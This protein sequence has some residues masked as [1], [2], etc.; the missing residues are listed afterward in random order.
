M[1][2]NYLKIAFRQLLRNKTF[3]AINI[4]GLAVGMS[5]FMLLALWVHNE[6]S[7]DRFHSKKERVYEL[8]NKAEWS[9]KLECWPVTP[10]VAAPTIRQQF[11]E[12][13]AAIHVDWPTER[14]LAIGDKKLG[15]R[16]NMVDPEF[17][18][19]FDFPLI[20][21]DIQTVLK[22]PHS[23]VLTAKLAKKIFGDENPVGKA[24]RIDNDYSV[25]VTGIIA[26]PPNNTRFQFDYLMPWSLHDELNG[27]ENNWGN[28]STH[29]YVLLKEHASICLLYTSPSPR[30]RG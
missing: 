16:G 15:A 12:V 3:S 13:E 27:K 18:S 19:M 10:I 30:D 9:G 22:E 20:S 4:L 14:F 24:I 11:P 25:T 5:A 6:L 7:F 21:G 29:T 28:N 1:F 26:N 23:I 17:L 2:K 8:W